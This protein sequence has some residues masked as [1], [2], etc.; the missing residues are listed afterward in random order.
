MAWPDCKDDSG[1]WGEGED[2]SAGKSVCYIS[3]RA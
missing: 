1:A 3:A 2:G